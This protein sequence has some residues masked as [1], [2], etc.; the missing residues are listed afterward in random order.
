MTALL[1]VR[2]ATRRFAGLIAV[3]DVSLT[4]AQGEILGLIGPNGA[5]KTTLI[6]LISGT[7]EPSDGELLFQGVSINRLPAFRRARLGIGRTFQIMRP[8]PGLSVLDNVAVGALFGRDGGQTRLA[9]ARE[10]ARACLEF[11]GLDKHIDQ[12]ADELGG[13]GRKRLEL[14]KALAM[15]PKLLL[16]DE[17]MAGL[18]HV[19][20]EEVIDLLRKVRDQGISILVIEHVIKAIK[21]LSDRLLVLHH[22]EKIADGTPEDVLSDPVVVQAYLGKKRP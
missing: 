6:S 13:A 17:I 11:V 19:E 21:S 20:I 15:Q 16:C 10:Q 7:L 4:L 12:R 2:H 22:G 3:N 8:F 18:N 9:P 5:G 1:E 14:A